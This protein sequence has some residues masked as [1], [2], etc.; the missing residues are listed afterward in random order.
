MPQNVKYFTWTMLIKLP[1]KNFPGRRT[2]YEQSQK[3]LS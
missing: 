2:N 1:L 3:G